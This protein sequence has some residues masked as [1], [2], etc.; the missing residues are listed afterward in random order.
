MRVRTCHVEL[1]KQRRGES[2]IVNRVT[3]PPAPIE[4]GPPLC[5]FRVSPIRQQLIHAARQVCSAKLKEGDITGKDFLN[6][7]FSARICWF[8]RNGMPYRRRTNDNADSD[9]Y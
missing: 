5:N 8:S 3:R 2:S 6:N 1:L 4:I 9:R 7:L